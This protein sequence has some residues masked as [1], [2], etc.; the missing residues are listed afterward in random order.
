MCKKSVFTFL[1]FTL[2]GFSLR[3]QNNWNLKKNK[4]GIRIYT[5]TD[6]S[7][8]INQIRVDMEMQGTISEMAAVMLDLK[9]HVKWSYA[10]KS[11]NLVRK[12]SES[13]LYFYTEMNSPWPLSNRDLIVH[14]LI[15]KDST[16]RVLNITEIDV[17]K[18]LPETQSIV[19]VPVSK[20]VWIITQVDMHTIHID[21]QIQID[22]GGSVPAWLVNMFATKCPY[23][24]FKNLSTQIA[25]EKYR[26]KSFP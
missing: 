25:L 16:K 9:D 12:I 10:T 5:R 26:Y 8:K 20:A 14:L 4:D 1:V 13:E 19:R 22:P 23:E 3:A 7:S 18:Y 6:Q 17:P 15:T 24:S 2:V 21:Y 11:C